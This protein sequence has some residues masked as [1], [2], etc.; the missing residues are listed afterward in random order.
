MR[1]RFTG[2][3]GKPW[4]FNLEG[5]VGWSGPIKPGEERDVPEPLGRHLLANPLFVEV[6]A[7]P[8]DQD[9]QSVHAA[10]E[11]PASD[12]AVKSPKRKSLSPK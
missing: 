4:S 10:L 7:G 11:E 6:G 3:P 9:F 12:K 2:Y 1:V 8:T 5:R